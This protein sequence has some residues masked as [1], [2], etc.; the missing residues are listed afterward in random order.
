MNP[1]AGWYPD[2]TGEGDQRYWDGATWTSHISVPE[3]KKG[4]RKATWAIIIW[5]VLMVIWLIAGVGG[6]ANSC[7]DL[8]GQFVNAKQSGC[9]AGASIGA[10][11]IIVIWFLGYIPLG[12]VWLMSR[13]RP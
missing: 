11:I 2:P 1:D 9:E 3:K 10:A 12:L 13:P 5:T 4:I 7:N 6:A 8:H